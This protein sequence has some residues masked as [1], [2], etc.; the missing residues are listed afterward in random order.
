MK[1]VKTSS[2][3]IFPGTLD[4]PLLE[5]VVQALHHVQAIMAIN[6]DETLEPGHLHGMTLILDNAEQVL[7]EMRSALPP[8]RRSPRP[9]APGSTAWPPIGQALTLSN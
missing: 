9:P 8:A 4:R 7:T 3:V 2:V 1:P 6:D 5:D